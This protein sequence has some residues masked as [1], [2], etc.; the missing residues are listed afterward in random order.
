VEITLAFAR[1]VIYDESEFKEVRERESV[2]AVPV[3][4][5]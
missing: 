5:E 4:Y 2:S 1:A 3:G